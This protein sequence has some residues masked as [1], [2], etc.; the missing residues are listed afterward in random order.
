MIES[1]LLGIGCK[2]KQLENVLHNHHRYANVQKCFA[3]YISILKS[4][5]LFPHKDK[6]TTL[7]KT[8]QY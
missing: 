1:L 5:E 2:N 7:K 8:I 6:K 3:F 4:A